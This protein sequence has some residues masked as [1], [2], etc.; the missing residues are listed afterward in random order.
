MRDKPYRIDRR[1]KYCWDLIKFDPNWYVPIEPVEPPEPGEPG[2]GTPS[3][4]VLPGLGG[5]LYKRYTS[6]VLISEEMTVKDLITDVLMPACR[7]WVNTGPLGKIRMRNKKPADYAYATSS[8]PIGTS[9]T[10]DD[11]SP[12][13]STLK[14]HIVI[15]PYTVNSEVRDVIAAVYPTSQNSV[16]LTTSNAGQMPVTAFSGAT[17]GATPATATVTI[18]AFTT[19]PATT[20]TITLDGIAIAFIPT[21]SDTVT[22]I[23]AFIAGAIQGDPRLNRRFV[24]TNVAGVVTIRARFGTLTLNAATAMTH[25]APVANPT[26]AVTL[27]ETASGNLP[28]GTYRVAYAFHSARGHTLVSPYKQITIA[29]SKKITTS[30]VTPPA[31]CTVVWYVS[32]ESE[33]S[34]LRYKTENNGTAIVIDWP[35]PLKTAAMAPALNRTGAEVMRVSAVYSDRGEV[36]SNIGVSNVL[37]GTFEWQLGSKKQKKNVVE[38]TYRQS[39]NDYRV[40]TLRER[41]DVNIAKVKERRTEKV[42]GLAIDNFYQAKR[43]ATGLLAEWMDA[44]FGYR[45]GSTRRAL[46]Q[47]EGDVVAITDGGSGVVNLPVWIEEK[48]TSC[49]NAGLPNVKFM[50]HKYYSSLYD[51]SVN[52]LDVPIVSE[53]GDVMAPS[54]YNVALASSGAVADASSEYGAGTYSATK[55]NDGYRHTQGSFLGWNS[56]AAPSGGS[57][58]W[59]RVTFAESKTISQIDAIFLKDA[60]NYSSEPTLSEVTTLYGVTDFKLQYWTGSV[61]TDIVAVAGNTNVW[62]QF[63]FPP[64]STTS[65]RIL[66]TGAQGGYARVIE[67]EAWGY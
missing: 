50:A 57:P 42:N 64:I 35:L 7:G 17:G 33:A 22:S 55:A 24:A 44:N 2:P 52:E 15:D 65:I 66:I 3:F 54:F 18:S 8:I 62:K 37:K 63:V 67:L 41:D 28:A 1:M 14:W 6:N 13:V 29:A 11:V 20:Y 46:L 12:W 25:V 10:V 53:L 58:E 23:A 48:D 60:I 39:A 56:N 38:L 45:W 27:T 34:K 59:L 21:T 47:E 16:T 49:P 5:Y 51:D 32:I 40:V 26:T 36:R 19:T 30:A 31:D 43:I 61:W 9:I 4:P